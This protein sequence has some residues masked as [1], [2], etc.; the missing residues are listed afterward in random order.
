MWSDRAC[1]FYLTSC[2]N[3]IIY[4][5]ASPTPHNYRRRI[6]TEVYRFGRTMIRSRFEGKIISSPPVHARSGLQTLLPQ[7]GS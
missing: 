1:A 4:R 5:S 7:D 2:N 6:I 3:Y